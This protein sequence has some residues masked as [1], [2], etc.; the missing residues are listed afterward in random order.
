MERIRIQPARLSSPRDRDFKPAQMD[1][2]FKQWIWN[3]ITS[4]CTVS[5]KIGLECFQHLIDTYNLEKH[6]FYRYLQLRNHFNKNINNEAAEL[7]RINIFAEAYKGGIHKKLLSKIYSCI[8]SSKSHSTLY[9]KEKWEKETNIILTE[10]D[11]FNICKSQHATSSSGQWRELSWKNVI[12]F[13]ITP[14]RKYLQNGNPESALCW[15]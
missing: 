15:R 9:V 2:R 5:S 8:Q 14:K 11:W 6:N 4:Y 7:S 3:G 10:E 12:R 13:F 1:V